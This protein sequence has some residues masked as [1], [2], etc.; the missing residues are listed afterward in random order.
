MVLG[1]RSASQ[2][3]RWWLLWSRSMM[4]LLPVYE[5]FYCFDYI[6]PGEHC[7]GCCCCC[8]YCPNSWWCAPA[9]EEDGW[10]VDARDNE[11]DTVPHFSKL[12]IEIYQ[13]KLLW[14]YE[15]ACTCANVCLGVWACAKGLLFSPE[16]K[17]STIK[18]NWAKLWRKS[19]NKLP[20]C[21]YTFA[22]DRSID[23]QIS[24]EMPK[25]IEYEERLDHRLW[26]T[27]EVSVAMMMMMRMML[28][29]MSTLT[30]G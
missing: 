11:E 9:R 22:I 17:M 20:N 16:T 29:T 27:L 30:S 3:V 7:F 15:C 13:H 24:R 26:W 4:L 1:V 12:W 10:R 25:F 5:F 8:Y 28:R 2:R 14:S 19:N 6:L 23:K 21:V 18:G